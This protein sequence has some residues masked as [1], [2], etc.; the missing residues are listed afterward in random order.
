MGAQADQVQDDILQRVLSR[1]LLP[2]DRI[3]EMDLRERLSLSGTPIREALIALE[4]ANVVERRPRDGARIAS[5][6]LE[7]LMKLIEVLAESEG[8]IANLAARRIN[9][10]QARMLEQKLEACTDFAAGRCAAAT[11]YFDLN[12]D[13]HTSL[14]VAAGNEHMGRSVFAVGNRLIAYLSARHNLPGEPARSAADHERIAAAVLDGNAEQARSLMID[15]VMFND[16]LAIDVMN[17]MK[18]AS[19]SWTP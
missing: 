12:L 19:Q 16:R 1:K 15:H 6:D 9:P 17:M 18:G 8:A 7:S 4:T 5:L 3:D 14:I 11:D 13:F 2:G 10:D